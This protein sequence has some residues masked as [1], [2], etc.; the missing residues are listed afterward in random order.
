MLEQ[1]MNEH[2][3]RRREIL[4]QLLSGETDLGRMAARIG[5]EPGELS[6]WGQDA[7]LLRQIRNLRRLM[8]AQVRLMISRC[9]M[10]AVWKLH[11]IVETAEGETA[12]K[13][14][15]DLLE[16]QLTDDEPIEPAAVEPGPERTQS[17]QRYL[18]ALGQE[19]G[20]AGS[21]MR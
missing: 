3:S 9:R 10:T 11:Q 21:D 8:D 15:V 17:V 14:C 13:A 20:D 12:R 4:D 5:A 16:S 2:R 6:E 18:A 1:D 7:A 19:E